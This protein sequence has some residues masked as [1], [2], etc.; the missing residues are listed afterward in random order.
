VPTADIRAITD[1]LRA[2]RGNDFIISMRLFWDPLED[3][4][5]ALKEM[6]D[7]Y[8]N[9]GVDA[10]IL[11]PRQRGLDDWLRA[12]EGLWNLLQPWHG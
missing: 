2:A 9:A 12:V 11:E 5:D 1:D 3:D 6:A 7:V 8:N 4:L 10:L